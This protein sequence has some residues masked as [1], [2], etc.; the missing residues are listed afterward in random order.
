[1]VFAFL[2]G[3]VSSVN[4]LTVSPVVIDFDLSPGSVQEKEITIINEGGIRVNVLPT[5][6]QVAGTD[7]SGFPQIQSVSRDAPLSRMISFPDGAEQS[8][9][10]GEKK[11][12]ALRVSAPPDISAGGYYGVV[13][14]GSSSVLSAA[15][16]SGQPGVN[17][18]I[19]VRGDV[20]E[21]ARIVS[22]S[23][24]SEEL[25]RKV[26]STLFEVSIQNVGGHHFVPEGKVEIRNIFNKRVAT[27]PLRS[28]VDGRASV[29]T[30]ILPGTSRTLFAR[31]EGAWAF[32]TYRALLTMDA[33]GAGI[34]KAETAFSEY[35]R[36]AVIT[37]LFIALSAVLTCIMILI[38]VL[39]K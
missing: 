35:S 24:K 8:L 1:M 16:L 7:E 26:E 31:W 34:L 28:R 18:A 39:K 25:A 21:G 27:L 33:Q 30:R 17:L 32:G 11:K 10:P 37:A 14:W 3:G 22:F 5:L 15:P 4:A 38:R 6:F 9:A 23:A 12:L 19:T 13:S 29:E 2:L 20:S 36:T